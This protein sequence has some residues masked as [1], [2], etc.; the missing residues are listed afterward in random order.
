MI[1]TSKTFSNQTHKV[2]NT[3]FKPTGWKRKIEVARRNF[4]ME[5]CDNET[6]VPP[7]VTIKSK[8]YDMTNVLINGYNHVALKNKYIVL[9]DQCEQSIV[10]IGQ[11]YDDIIVEKVSL[12]S[13][14]RKEKSNYDKLDHTPSRVK[15]NEN[16]ELRTIES[17]FKIVCR[18]DVC[19]DPGKH[20]SI[21]RA[22]TNSDL[23]DMLDSVDSY[24]PELG[25]CV[26]LRVEYD[27][28]HQFL[29]IEHLQR[30]RPLGNSENHP[31]RDLRH[32]K[33]GDETSLI[34]ASDAATTDAL[35][36]NVELPTAPPMPPSEDGGDRVELKEP[37][38]EYP[39]IEESDVGDGR[40]WF[41]TVEDGN[42]NLGKEGTINPIV[43]ILAPTELVYYLKFKHFMKERTPALFNSMVMDARLFYRDKQ[44]NLT[45]KQQ[46]EEGSAAVLAAYFVDKREL[47][48][49]K[50][51]RTRGNLV[52][53]DKIGQFAQGNLGGGFWG[54]L[55]TRFR[56]NR[57]NHSRLALSN[58]INIPVI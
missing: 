9:D 29:P 13:I 28:H 18:P 39:I 10:D 57:I 47:Q 40:E 33:T 4:L 2:I 12:R 50:A 49:R 16:A 46:Y 19:L 15:F 52:A 32:P 6:Y 53:T 48:V 8:D 43:K 25:N 55:Y 42:T 5:R 27:T 36:R 20:E 54:S 26:C 7:N 21:R 11:L 3:Y 51:I 34:Q 24:A 17:T 14:L 1:V 58:R 23:H 37:V 31:S 45:Y 35:A 41:S 44:S 56:R 22:V 38:P 30:A